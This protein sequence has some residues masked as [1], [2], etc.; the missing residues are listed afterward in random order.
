MTAVALQLTDAVQKHQAGDLKDAEQI[1]REILRH[2]PDDGDALNLLGVLCGQTGRPDEAVGYLERAVKVRPGHPQS[3]HNLGNMYRQIGRLNEALAESEAALRAAP[4]YAAAYLSRGLILWDLGRLEDALRSLKAV[5]DID[6]GHLEARAAVAERLSESG[7]FDEAIEDWQVLVEAMPDNASAVID[8]GIALHQAGRIQEA[9]EQFRVATKLQPDVAAT[10]C[11]LGASLRI[12]GC[13][14]E[15]ADAL[16]RAVELDP[17]LLAA[18]TN[19]ASACLGIKH[20]SRAMQACR[21]AL[22]IAPHNASAHSVAAKALLHA[23]ELEMAEHHFRIAVSLD[24]DSPDLLVDLGDVLRK[25]GRLDEA[26]IEFNR[27][28]KL[29]PLCPDALAARIGLLM[30]Q[31]KRDAALALADESM[32]RLPNEVTIASAAANAY[33]E[34]RRYDRAASVLRQQISH[35]STSP[36]Q[37]KLL[38]FRLGDA[39]D[40]NGDLDAAWGV[41][42]QANGLKEV[43]F[44]RQAIRE[45]VQATIEV[46]SGPRLRA[47]PRAEAGPVRPIFIAGMPRTGTTLVEQILDTHP[48]LT[49][50]GEIGLMGR[51]VGRIEPLAGIPDQFPQS[52]ARLSRDDVQAL[53]RFACDEMAKLAPDAKF[54]TEKTTSNFLC[55]GLVEMLFPEA[56]VIWCLRDPLDT[57]VSCY[58]H[59]F[60]GS[61]PF[62]YDLGNLGFYYRKHEEL[63]DHWRQAL[64]MPLMTVRYEDMVADQEKQTRDLLEFCGLSWHDDCLNFH[65][66]KRVAQTA[67]IQQVR[68]PIYGTSVGRYQRYEKYLQPLK[69]ALAK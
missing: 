42:Q 4:Q 31:D 65:R 18:H 62:T 58:L 25:Q 56:R 29:D 20:L 30:E 49:G 8:L 43:D 19:L 54:I 68:S 66:N 64:E 3:H 52:V 45:Q 15:A 33:I 12:A 36:A 67:S 13:S 9:V 39:L 35:P 27:A 32:D 10:W 50:L 16:E 21:V 1:Y 34:G 24:P 6:P 47:A 57:C 22:D 38:L 55:L 14:A 48:D 28:L 26:D 37:R 53:S 51:I 11:N 59:D 2:T 69:D 5:L 63:L 46:F 17:T 23:A 60:T 44:S 61:L 7:R 41:Y 40:R